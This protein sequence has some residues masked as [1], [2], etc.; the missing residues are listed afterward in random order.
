VTQAAALPTHLLSVRAPRL[1]ASNPSTG[2]VS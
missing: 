1:G 2:R